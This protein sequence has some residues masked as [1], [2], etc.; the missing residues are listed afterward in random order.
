MKSCIRFVRGETISMS[1]N[2]QPLRTQQEINDFL[3]CLRRNKNAD[4]DVFLFLIGINSGLRMSDIVKLKKKDILSAK[5]PRIVEQKTGKTR[6]LYLSS[7]Q[8]LIQEYTKDLNP[9]EYLFPSTK[10]GHLEVNTVYQMFQKVAKLLGRD[11]I[12]THTLRKTFGYHYYKKTKDVATLMEIF[13]H[14]SE[15]ITK[16]YIGINEDEISETLLNFRLGF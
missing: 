4:R 3:F 6:I 11:D 7:L 8:D 2:V 13:G 9:E 14:S 5:N 1:Y 16:R 10:G 12:G 15:K